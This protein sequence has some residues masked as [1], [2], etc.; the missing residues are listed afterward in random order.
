MDNE[1]IWCLIPLF[2]IFLTSIKLIF[3]FAYYR[4]FSYV[5]GLI[6]LIVYATS[7][8]FALIFIYR[9]LISIPESFFYSNP[10]STRFFL[11]LFWWLIFELLS[12]H[13]RIRYNLDES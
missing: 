4:E 3:N 8:T 5:F 1:T 2:V 6:Q 11:F 10:L 9:V 12:K 7:I 13:F